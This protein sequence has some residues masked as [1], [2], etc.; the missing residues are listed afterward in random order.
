M[1]YHMVADE[2][3]PL[4]DDIMKPYASRHLTTEQRLFNYRLSRA[5]RVVEN[6]FGIMCN[7]FRVF[8]TTIALAPEKVQSLVLA[9]CALHN[10]LLSNSD[11]RYVSSGLSGN[12]DCETHVLLNGQWRQQWQL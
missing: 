9:A 11:I 10:F 1:L 12:V 2:T 6:A 8:L 3:F 4:R 7:R 5:R